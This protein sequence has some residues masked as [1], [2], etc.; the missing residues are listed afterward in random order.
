M[1]ASFESRRCCIRAGTVMPISSAIRMA[2]VADATKPS[3]RIFHAT[4]SRGLEQYGPIQLSSEPEHAEQD[5]DRDPLQAPRGSLTRGD[6]VPES[7]CNRSTLERKR[8]G[9]NEKDQ[10]HQRAAD[11]QQESAAIGGEFLGWFGE[12][13]TD[14]AS[15]TLFTPTAQCAVEFETAARTDS[16]AFT[17]MKSNRSNRSNRTY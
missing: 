4:E 7:E 13:L 8:R 16:Q 9:L 1:P 14:G 17:S 6:P 10:D 11:C 15:A 5:R 2:T 12:W 3:P